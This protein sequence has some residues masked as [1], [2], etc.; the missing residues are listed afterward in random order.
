MLLIQF[1]KKTIYK[2]ALLV[3]IIMLIG[4]YNYLSSAATAFITNHEI[5][6]MQKQLYKTYSVLGGSFSFKLPETWK[7]WTESF[8]G[9]E[10]IYHL[11]FIS[12]DN[13]IKGFVQVWNMNKPL[14]QFIK[15]SKK[16]AVGIVGF[17][18]YS[19][20]EIMVGGRRGYLLEYSRKNEEG[21]TFRSY[22]AF[23]EGKAGRVYRISF[24][25]DQNDW[26]EHYV[27]IFNLIIQ[28][29]RITE[30]IT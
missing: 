25:V 21:Q 10:I 5:G 22:E 24:F 9:E 3:S 8:S 26:K 20:K 6:K 23:I 27:T 11:Y 4:L 7:T 17:E 28:S 13:R 14:K 1:K 16:A 15:E 30:S 19:A 29:M 2:I 12:N 18:S